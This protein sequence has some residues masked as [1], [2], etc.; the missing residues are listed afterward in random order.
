[1]VVKVWRNSSLSYFIQSV[2]RCF[3]AA[4]GAQSQAGRCTIKNTVQY[5]SVNIRGLKENESVEVLVD[6]LHK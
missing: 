5:V 4:C 2:F 6:Q 1:M 3:H